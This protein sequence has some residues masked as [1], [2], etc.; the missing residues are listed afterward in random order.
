VGLVLYALLLLTACASSSGPSAEDE[1]TKKAVE[2]ALANI[3]IDKIAREA[4]AK[5]NT[6][7]TP[8]PHDNSVRWRVYASTLKSNDLTG[9]RLVALD[10]LLVSI[11]GANP[12]LLNADKGTLLWEL[13]TLRYD[14]SEFGT[15]RENR[16]LP[17]V[18]YP[19][20]AFI[21]AYKDM[22]LFRADGDKSSKILAVETATGNK[23]WSVELEKSGEL[24]FIPYPASD[25]LVAVQQDKRRATLTT[26]NISTGAVVW[27]SDTRY[28]SG[29]EQPPVPTTDDKALWLFY[30]GVVKVAAE[31]GKRQWHRTDILAGE[32]SPPMQ[33]DQARLY[34]LDGKNTLHILDSRSGKTLA[35]G[36]QRED[37]VYTNIFPIG[38]RVYLRGVE[39]EKSGEPRFFVAAV[40]STDAKEL[41]MDTDRDPSVSNLIDENR[42]LY[43]ST[44]F[45]VM[46]LD[47]ETGSRRF[48][49][50][51]SDVG[52]SF[53]VQ[54]R[55][56]GDKV[57]YIGELVIAAFDAKTGAKVYRHGFDPINQT[58]HMDALNQ[59][60]ESKQKFLSWFTGPWSDL[61][62]K[63]L[64]MS[65]FFFQQ[66]A[67]SQNQSN[68]AWQEASKYGRTYEI[69]GDSLAATRSSIKA[70]ESVIDS[71]FSRAQ[72]SAGMAFMT[73][74][75]VQRGIAEATAADRKKLREL[76]RI[77]KL[78]YA[79]YVVTQQGDYVYRP[80][81]EADAVGISLIH[82][83]TGRASYT[84]LTPEYD[85]IGVFSL[86]DLNK[87]LVYHPQASVEKKGFI[88]TNFVAR[89]VKV[90]K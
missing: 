8:S 47:R 17:P 80:T 51:A 6:D 90:P 59:V 74:E 55:K 26:F 24:L 81:K 71:S 86:V 49:V 29:T 53:P 62:L 32:Q 42:T 50:R 84:D 67:Y 1:R 69:T 21:M 27:K 14:E 37:A 35:S 45:T 57:V 77:R 56:Y 89:P 82:L 40:R 44:P 63:S 48:A 16:K 75:N 20:Y 39:K 11:D 2:S 73:V 72:F 66:A 10:K 7:F 60:I 52:K 46:A 58:A 25:V 41:W 28:G 54:I 83:P 4:V 87:G 13:K 85:L 3:N 70:H 12:C 30:D 38:D 31:N 68:Y 64:G 19:S 36:K 79:A 34:V 22:L 43:F 61:D 65:E 76:L 78:L 88:D 5:S 23:R 33:L 18:K 15:S 9:L